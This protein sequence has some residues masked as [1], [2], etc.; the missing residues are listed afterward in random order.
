MNN[1]G[2]NFVASLTNGLKKKYCSNTVSHG[3]LT[4][5]ADAEPQIETDCKVTSGF[6]T[7]WGVAIFN[8]LC[9]SRVNYT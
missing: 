8:P 5:S 3:R 2:L 7:A 1:K 9:P 4:E 6:S